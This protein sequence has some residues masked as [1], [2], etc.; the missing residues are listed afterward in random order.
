MIQFIREKRAGCLVSLGIKLALFLWYCILLPKRRRKRR[1]RDCMSVRPA[2]KHWT[3]PY[4]TLPCFL[5]F[6]QHSNTPPPRLFFQQYPPPPQFPVH[7][8]PFLPLSFS[9]FSQKMFPFWI[10]FL[11]C[12]L[13]LIPNK[14]LIA[15]MLSQNS[16]PYSANFFHGQNLFKTK[17][18]YAQ[19]TRP[20][21]SCY[22]CLS[23]HGF[24]TSVGLSFFLLSFIMHLMLIELWYN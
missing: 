21:V 5:P 9:H 15:L 17:G 4:V 10:Y 2:A 7:L 14:F 1:W 20:V 13:I 8:S 11:S 12:L 22:F 6:I 16:P 19:C 23:Y 18:C 24:L 3:L